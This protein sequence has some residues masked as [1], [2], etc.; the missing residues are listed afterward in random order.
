MRG[1]KRLGDGQY[2]EHFKQLRQKFDGGDPFVNGGHAVRGGAATSHADRIANTPEWTGND[3]TVRELLL[4][5]FPK[6]HEDESQRE[7]AAQ[8]MQIINLYFRVGW[9]QS[10]IAQELD[11]TAA[12]VGSTIRNIKRVATGRQSNNAKERG[13]KPRGRPR[14]NGALT[15]AANGDDVQEN[16]GSKEGL[17]TYMLSNGEGIGQGY[18]AIP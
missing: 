16:D 18:P 8:W 5:A 4:T 3:Q 14:L 17:G 13:V 7:R 2:D 9:A 15:H 6:L 1:Y 12:K 11:W 10:R